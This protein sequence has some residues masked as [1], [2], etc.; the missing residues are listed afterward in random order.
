[1][2]YWTQFIHNYLIFCT[3][4][5]ISLNI[6]PLSLSPM[7]FAFSFTKSSRASTFSMQISHL[8]LC[9]NMLL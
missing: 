7:K 8:L 2:H 9:Q 3:Y 5:Y 1:M 6:H 4:F